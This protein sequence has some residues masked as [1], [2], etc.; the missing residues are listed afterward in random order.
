MM[1]RPFTRE[2]GFDVGGAVRPA[3]E[4]RPLVEHPSRIKNGAP[5][6]NW[7]AGV[8]PRFTKRSGDLLG[9]FGS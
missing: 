9:D 3:A 7:N 4:D 6:T 8:A 5:A 2:L 1:R